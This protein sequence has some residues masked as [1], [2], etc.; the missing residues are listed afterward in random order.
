MRLEVSDARRWRSGPT[1]NKQ[2]R[3][4][5]GGD[6]S[7]AVREKREGEEETAAE[8]DG[9]MDD[10]GQDFCSHG[11][12]RQDGGFFGAVG[13]WGMGGRT[14]GQ[15]QGRAAGQGW[16]GLDGTGECEGELQVG[17][18]PGRERGMYCVG[19]V[20][21]D[22]RKKRRQLSGEGGSWSVV[23]ALHRHPRFMASHGWADWVDGGRGREPRAR[24][25][26]RG[27]ESSFLVGASLWW[28][29]L[30]HKVGVRSFP[31]RST[32]RWA[33]PLVTKGERGDG[34]AALVSQRAKTRSKSIE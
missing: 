30:G 29:V 10:N 31:G 2:E 24:Y 14:E 34:L 23:V 3:R 8:E 7:R 13:Q 33:S 25:G 11:T 28:Q 19:V 21:A 32:E 22:T 5:E 20:V 1:R 26:V 9:W 27:P 6:A 12:A 18:E 16:A 4:E 15:G 17:W